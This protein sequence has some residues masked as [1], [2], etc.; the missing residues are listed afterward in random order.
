MLVYP[1]FF[2]YYFDYHYLII[3][4]YPIC[5]LISFANHKLSILKFQFQNQQ[6]LIF[7]FEA[8]N[9]SISQHHYDQEFF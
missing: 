2:A 6:I 9:K 4:N 8:A 1:I 7:C 5:L 3:F